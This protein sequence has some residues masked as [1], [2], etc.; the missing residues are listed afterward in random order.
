MHQMYCPRPTIE[1]PRLETGDSA[2]ELP[3]SEPLGRA[4]I[5]A[6]AN[7]FKHPLS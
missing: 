5:S 6:A 3:G 1:P 2:I 4:A 7:P